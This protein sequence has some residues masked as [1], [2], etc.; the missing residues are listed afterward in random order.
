ML[1]KIEI[2]N[3]AIID[4]LEIEFPA[5]L[6]IITGETGAG[7]SILLGALG[8]IMGKRADTR[9]LYDQ[10][11]KCFVEATFDVKA[12]RLEDFFV[13]EGL[14]YMDE[15][16][17]RREIASNGKSR[18]FVNDSPVTLDILDKLTEG[19]IDIHQQFDT[20]DIQKPSFQ[21][22]M[23]DALAGNKNLLETYSKGIKLYRQALRKLEELKEKNR[24]AHQEMEFL[25]FQMNEFNQAELKE[26]EQES[27]EAQLEKLTS[28]E[29]IKKC[30]TLL[31]HGLEEDENAIIGQIQGLVNHISSIKHLD[32]SYNEIYDRLISVREELAD[33]AKEAS[34]MAEA[35]E[36]DE[37]A[38][39]LANARLNLINRLQKKHGVIT[40]QALLDIQSTI[41]QKL[42][43][44]SD[45]T[46]EIEKMEASCVKQ[47]TELRKQALSLSDLRKKIIPTFEKNVHDLLVGLSMEHAYIKVK[48]DTLKEL[49]STG[50]DDLSILFAP[51]K[52]SGFLPLKDTAS[53]GEISRLTLCVKSLVAGAVTLP[54][55]IF[56]E[57]DAGVSGDVAQKMGAILSRM[58]EKHQIICITHSPQIAARAESH[59]WVYKSETASRTMTAMRELTMD[60]RVIEIAKML[61]GNPPTE[62]AKANARELIGL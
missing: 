33:V 4:K 28:A 2:Q 58:S 36:Y 29:D 22:Q 42:N 60:D 5:G 27:L 35:T 24:N 9:V 10:E 43:G 6:T 26:G 41:E 53:G 55:L 11:R 52:G 45:L 25:S 39:Y 54:T 30:T 17:I 16:V 49:S 50:L 31:V 51:N 7:K 34:S 18:A 48:I 3:Y 21:L 46:D 19:L 8:L 1:R 20:L 47:E 15:L 14:D 59:Y 61:S 32:K 13:E 23:I 40:M 56:D 62:T 44:Y 38:I 12:Y 57:I 37:E